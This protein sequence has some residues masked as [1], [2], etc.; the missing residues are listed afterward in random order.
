M[1]RNVY[2]TCKKE[3]KETRV[4]IVAYHVN[5]AL[6]YSSDSSGSGMPQYLQLQLGY[7]SCSP[8]IVTLNVPVAELVMRSVADK[9]DGST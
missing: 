8:R 9:S 2:F 7:M 4:R 3:T 5:L 6:D 1:L